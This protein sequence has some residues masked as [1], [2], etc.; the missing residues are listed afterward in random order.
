M[1]AGRHPPRRR[2]RRPPRPR[3]RRL[4]PRRS[5][6][7]AH[8]DALATRSVSGVQVTAP[9]GTVLIDGQPTVTGVMKRTADRVDAADGS[10]ST[11]RG[12]TVSTAADGT[13]DV[14]LDSFEQIPDRASDPVAEYRWPALRVYGLD[15][16]LTPEGT[17]TVD[18]VN[19]SN[20]VFVNGGVDQHRHRPVHRRRR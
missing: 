11:A 17:M 20:A 1:T 14:H 4:I 13:S 15:A 9:D 16:H 5:R 6:T 8:G 18:F 12:V 3:L 7:P 19:E 2:R 10:P